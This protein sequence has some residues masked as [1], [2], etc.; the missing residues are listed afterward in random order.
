ML[1]LNPMQ[2]KSS[3]SSGLTISILMSICL[4]ACQASEPETEV[5]IPAPPRTTTSSSAVGGDKTQAQPGFIALPSK[6]DVT[7]SYPT[8]RLDPFAP[9]SDLNYLPPPR[10]VQEGQRSADRSQSRSAPK[11]SEDQVAKETQ[12][13]RV[14]GVIGSGKT[15]FAAVDYGTISGSVR[16][17]DEGGSSGSDA[18]FLLPDGWRVLAINARSGTITI[19]KKGAKVFLAVGG[20]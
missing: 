14:T 11:I 4:A 19:G 9:V 17:G 18:E 20:R 16:V 3:N 12:D 5:L 2:G 7:A 8:G 1:K 10:F 6:E 15:V 13:L